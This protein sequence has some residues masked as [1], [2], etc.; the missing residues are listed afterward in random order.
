MLFL[1]TIAQMIIFFN[2]MGSSLV[3]FTD[4]M[5]RL[6]NAELGG[7]GPGEIDDRNFTGS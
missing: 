5:I 2:E 6:L 4:L 1:I 3:V 7:N